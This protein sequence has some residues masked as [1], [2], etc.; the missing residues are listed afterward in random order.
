VAVSGK[1]LVGGGEGPVKAFLQP[2]EAQ[3]WASAMDQG[4]SKQA[5]TARKRNIGGPVWEYGVTFP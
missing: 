1:F 3:P 5:E 4:P 2:L